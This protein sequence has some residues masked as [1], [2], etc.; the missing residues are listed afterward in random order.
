MSPLV[1]FL[2]FLPSLSKNCISHSVHLPPTKKNW[3]KNVCITTFM[4]MESFFA[5]CWR[6]MFG[7]F[8]FSYEPMTSSLVWYLQNRAFMYICRFILLSFPFCSLWFIL[9]SMPFWW[10]WWYFCRRLWILEAMLQIYR[11][12]G[13]HIML[14]L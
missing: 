1:P 2:F 7:R 3:A 14:L 11:I 8:P 4:E 6:T 12:R 10:P 13:S 9:C 5:L